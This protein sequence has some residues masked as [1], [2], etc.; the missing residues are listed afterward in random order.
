MAR[1]Q[2]LEEIRNQLGIVPEEFNQLPDDVLEHEWALFKIIQH[3]NEVIPRKYRQLIG[4]AVSAAIGNRM[5][6]FAHREM[7]KAFGASDEE[8]IDTLLVAKNNTGWST[9]GVGAGMEYEKYRDEIR[10][11]VGHLRQMKKAA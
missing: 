6:S 9:F 1:G 7:A 8:I 10:Q 5:W 3:R 11:E 2:I 4:L